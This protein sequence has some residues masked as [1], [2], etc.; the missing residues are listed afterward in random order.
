MKR[1]FRLFCRPSSSAAPRF[2]VTCTH[3]DSFGFDWVRND[4][5]EPVLVLFPCGIHPRKDRRRWHHTSGKEGTKPTEKQRKNDACREGRR[6][7]GPGKAEESMAR[8]TK[9][10]A[11]V[12]VRYND[13]RVTP[14]LLACMKPATVCSSDGSSTLAKPKLPGMCT[15]A[16]DDCSAAVEE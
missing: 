1:T 3:H 15:G 12:C 6:K 8:C 7:Q 9:G 14:E 13:A 4:G 11:N 5:F 2:D 16:A 10:C